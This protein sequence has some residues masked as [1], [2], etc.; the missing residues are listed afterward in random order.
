MVFS[1]CGVTYGRA[2]AVVTATG[3]DTEVGRIAGLL[4]SEK[5]GQT[6]FRKTER[7]AT[8]GLIALAAC[9]VVFAVGILDGLEVMEMFMTAVSLAVSAIP[10][11]LPA[12]VTIVLS[13]GVSRMVKKTP[14]SAACR[15]RNAGQRLRSSARIRPARSPK[16]A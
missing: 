13:V 10:E 8:L 7:L 16:T 6:L 9:A 14:S 5:E 4:S 3:M 2:D 1:G 12:I 11:G 15:R